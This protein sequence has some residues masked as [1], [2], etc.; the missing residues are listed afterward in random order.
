MTARP[1]THRAASWLVFALLANTPVLA[2]EGCR[3]FM[4]KVGD[5]EL[6]VLEN[7]YL[8]VTFDP[9]QGGQCV[10][11]VTKN[12]K[13][14]EDDFVLHIFDDMDW[15][16]HPHRYQPFSFVEYNSEITR[17]TP[18]EAALHLWKRGKEEFHFCIVH[19]HVHLAK[20]EARVRVVYE[21]GNIPEAMGS[22]EFRLNCHNGLHPSREGA[23]YLPTTQG[24]RRIP[25]GKSGMHQWSKDP[26]R[27][28]SGVVND[29]LAGIGCAMQFG[30]LFLLYDWLG[31]GVATM[32][33]RFLPVVIDAGKSFRTTVWLIPFWGLQRVDHQARIRHRG[34]ARSVD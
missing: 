21:V 27:A 29:R 28:W 5:K 4:Q 2:E 20:D 24:V 10:G 9:A 1:R 22:R 14:A 3:A 7:P 19:K 6:A 17:N 12:G 23:F 30:H 16:R 18:K 15:S 11:L 25:F 33:W 8:R 32:E 13:V 34:V 31:K 26:P